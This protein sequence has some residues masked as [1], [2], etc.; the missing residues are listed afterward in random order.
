MDGDFDYF[1]EQW[2][3]PD[4]EVEAEGGVGYQFDEFKDVV[5][6]IDE[7][8]LISGI[9]LF[10]RDFQVIS[11]SVGQTPEDVRLS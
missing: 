1:I 10:N 3:E 9:D 11:T 4:N 8:R 2:G 6:Y 5:F 7:L